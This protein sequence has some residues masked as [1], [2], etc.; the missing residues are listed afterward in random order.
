MKIS[1]FLR[2]AVLGSLF[3]LGAFPV[4]G[5]NPTT[6]AIQPGGAAVVRPVRNDYHFGADL[7]FMKQ[8]E[9]GGF[10]FKENGEVKPGMKIFAGHG[11]NW[12]RLR[13]M[14]TPS[15]WTGGGGKLPNDLQYTIAMAKQAKQYGMKFL[16]DYH[17]SD[18]WADPGKQHIP[19]AWVG[20]SQDELVKAVYGYTLETMRACTPIWCRW[21]TK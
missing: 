2:T 20:K 9:D 5:Q 15:A 13:L 10:K 21:A 3:A 7:S 12:V 8:A 6:G 11:Y 4:S 19:A 16:L 1:S 14:H 17:Y 18:T